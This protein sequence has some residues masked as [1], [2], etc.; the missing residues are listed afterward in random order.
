MGG[1]GSGRPRKKPY[2]DFT[3]T[4]KGKFNLNSSKRF[5]T[6]AYNQNNQKMYGIKDLF[7]GTTYKRIN[8]ETYDYILRRF[9]VESEDKVLS[10]LDIYTKEGIANRAETARGNI[11]SALNNM[12]D[13]DA[14]FS[15][16]G[17][18]YQLSEIID[19][20]ENMQYSERWIEFATRYSDLVDSFFVGYRAEI[21]IAPSEMAG[22][23]DKNYQENLSNEQ[24]SNASDNYEKMFGLLED[25]VKT[26]KI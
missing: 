9:A 23:G 5:K 15:I 21:G 14:T 8:P 18:E 26:F 20:L 7:T 2:G 6:F 17:K 4:E 16:N 22:M 25:L 24:D 12:Y 10:R 11:I 1:F 13:S 19:K 3:L